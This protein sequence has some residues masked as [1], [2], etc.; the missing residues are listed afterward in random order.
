MKNNNDAAFWNREVELEAL[1]RWFERRPRLGVLHGRR[2]LGKTSL[3]RR[4]LRE[5]PG[6]YVQA[7]EGTPAS[8][9]AAM[10][11]DLQ[12][13]LPGFGDVV[14]P[15]WRVLLDSLKR[16]WP[17]RSTVLVIDEFPYLCGP[18]RSFPRCCRPWSM[19]RMPDGCR[20]SSAAPASG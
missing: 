20:S 17:A 12:S 19:R 11:E 9:R 10:V 6:C 1:R 16:R 2:R 7:T 18:R 5:A 14:Y 3:I 8:Q 13:V 15:S 4:W